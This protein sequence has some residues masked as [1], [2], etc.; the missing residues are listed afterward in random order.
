MDNE[1]IVEINLGNTKGII[2][3]LDNLG[4]VVLP[5]EF[6]KELNFNEEDEIEIF[7]LQDGLF[8]RKSK[9]QKNKV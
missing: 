4:R 2:R 1:N 9:I 7:L 5:K 3:H 8:M 6:R